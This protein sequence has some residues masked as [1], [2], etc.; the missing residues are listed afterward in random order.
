MTATEKVSVTIGREEL[1]D[2]KRI[3]ARLGLSLST[4]VTAAVRRQVEEQA[5]RDAA[6]EVLASF[7]PEDRATEQEMSDLLAL[8]ASD[9]GRK[10][11]RP[12]RKRR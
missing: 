6:L 8:W 5:R 11:A 2:A 7:A 9:H 3:A 1:R 4:F 10:P 12:R